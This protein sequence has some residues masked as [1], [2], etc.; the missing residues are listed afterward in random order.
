[1]KQRYDSTG[2]NDDE[3]ERLL[4]VAH[5]DHYEDDDSHSNMEG[6]RKHKSKSSS[7]SGGS[8]WRSLANCLILPLFLA[9]AAS[10]AFSYYL[11]TKIT[12]LSSQLHSL[13]SNVKEI[14]ADISA[15]H[16]QLIYVNETLA[17]HSIVVAR[18]EHTVSN[19]DVLQKLHQLEQDSK[20][21]QDE[22]DRSL[23]NTKTGIE[24]NLA[25]TQH[26]INQTLETARDL[27]TN[28]VNSV[29][30]TLSSYIRTTQDQFSTENSFMIY[31]L[32]GTFTLLGCL[33]SMWHMTD[34]LRNFEQPFVQRKILAILWMCPIYSITSWLSLVIPAMEGYLAMLKDLYE[35]Y[36]IYQFLSFLI[37]VLGKGDR[38]AV[39]DLLA[40]HA[41]HLSPPVRCF[42][43]CRKRLGQG[44]VCNDEKR[45]LADDVLLQ[46]Q[47]CAMQFV[48]LRPFLTTVKFV[49]KKIDYNGP[50]FGPGNPFDSSGGG[51][52]GV[53]SDVCTYIGDGAIPYCT[54]HFW[55]VIAENVSVFLAFSGL[56]NFYHAVSEDLSW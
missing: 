47:I 56:L 48:F 29:Q 18:F 21:R 15:Q 51:E 52:M 10:A 31:Q 22:I 46:C 17:N 7:S 9:A 33:I 27:I 41:D 37:A 34:H 36:V 40:R 6:G 53:D 2:R 39:V 43:C 45:Q 4:D 54:P 26:D 28:Q 16:H 1:M 11:Q 3:R 14:S 38:G 25:Q 5:C 19:S 23:N 49:L 44:M 35:A 13:D 20:R 8:C 32:A 42:G 24:T 12:V 30:D 50:L 55:L